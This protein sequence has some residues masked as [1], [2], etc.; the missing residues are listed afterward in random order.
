MLQVLLLLLMIPFKFWLYIFF[1]LTIL[2]FY[3]KLVN[4]N[5]F[6]NLSDK[7]NK[8]FGSRG[9]KIYNQFLDIKDFFSGNWIIYFCIGASFVIWLCTGI[10]KVE[11]NEEAAILRFGKL[12]RIVKPGLHWHIPN[13]F[14]STIVADVTSLHK[15]GTARLMKQKNTVDKD[16]L[17]LTKD[18]NM[19]SVQFTIFWRVNNL[20]QY[21]F[22]ACKPE[23]IVQ[24][25]AETVMREIISNTMTQDAIT[26]G[27][28]EISDKI[29]IK[30]QNLIDTYKI[31]IDIVDAQIGKIDPPDSVIDAYRDVMKAKSEQET[32]KNQAESYA[33][34]VIP[35]A[36]GKAFEILS[37]AEQ[38]KATILA[39]ANGQASAFRAQVNAFNIN[40]GLVKT[41]MFTKVFEKIFGNSKSI[42]IIDSDV[43]A[44]INV[45]TAEAG[46]IGNKEKVK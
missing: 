14:E 17:V 27:R 39:D 31:G 15:I 28:Q 20:E 37:S 41:I 46:Q 16:I 38:E 7:I 11:L 42:N 43:N 18:E 24:S 44:F 22:G 8:T 40:K 5:L 33:S 23:G 32:Q 36:E 34:Y 19:V 35:N 3:T 6:N 12:H 9:Q 13:P 25:A 30:L 26:I 21:L 4:R 2:Y 45:G 29:K 10:F 1:G